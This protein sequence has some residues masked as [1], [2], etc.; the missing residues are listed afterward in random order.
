MSV[1]STIMV[2]SIFGRPSPPRMAARCQ[3]KYTR[4]RY[5]IRATHG[6]LIRAVTRKP[7]GRLLWGF[8]V[9]GLSVN[10]IIDAEKPSF[11]R[12]KD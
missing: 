6:Y 8:V 7:L 4:H 12:P 10:G 9:F 1:A 11:A 3:L 2:A 5:A